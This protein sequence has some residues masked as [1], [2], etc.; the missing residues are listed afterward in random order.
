[1]LEECILI[2]MVELVWPTNEPA[3]Y[4]R[5]LVKVRIFP[6]VEHTGDKIRREE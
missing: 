6:P 3:K 1:M 2:A 5:I 4:R